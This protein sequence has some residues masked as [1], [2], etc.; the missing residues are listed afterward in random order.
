MSAMIAKEKRISQETFDEVVQENIEE[1]D[2]NE[3][4]ALAEAIKQ[5]QSQGVSFANLDISGGIGRAEM[6]EAMSELASC[7]VIGLF[8]SSIETI[9]KVS[10]LCGDKCE[11]G[12]RNRM[13]M[14]PNGLNSLHKLF[15]ANTHAE[16]LIGALNLLTFLSKNSIET[17]DFFEPGGSKEMCEILLVRLANDFVTP[18][19]CEIMR[20]A[21]SLA[22]CAAKS[23][24]NKSKFIYIYIL[25]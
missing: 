15:K 4:D 10:L 24:N 18:T 17:R 5:F 3:K 16:T 1:F 21:F 7:S 11:M 22:R 9:Q 23:E 12:A 14:N 20:A 6:L 8:S 2:M 19:N 13:L 25:I